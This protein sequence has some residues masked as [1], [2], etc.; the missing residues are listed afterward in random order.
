MGGD[1]DRASLNGARRV[2][3]SGVRRAMMMFVRRL[4][5]RR[6]YREGEGQAHQGRE[7]ANGVRTA[8]TGK[9]RSYVLHNERPG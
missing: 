2:V 8:P 7:D 5:G 3:A 6:R 9:L 1:L 4:L